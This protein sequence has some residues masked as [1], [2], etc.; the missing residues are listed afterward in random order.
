MWVGSKLVWVHVHVVSG[1]GSFA[2]PFLEAV[3]TEDVPTRGK[4]F[5]II[6]TSGYVYRKKVR[7]SR[8]W[9]VED[10]HAYLTLERC[11]DRCDELG[12][13][14]KG[15]RVARK[16]VD[17]LHHSSHIYFAKSVPLFLTSV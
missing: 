13:Y 8:E 11:L 12:A 2:K 5:V 14:M 6:A 7:H 4:A 9:L 3:Q 17:V 15:G 10:V 1:R 16:R